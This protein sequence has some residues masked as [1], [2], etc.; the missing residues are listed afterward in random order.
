MPAA[1][2][3]VDALGR[4]CQSRRWAHG[5][6]P[7]A[8][9]GAHRGPPEAPP[10]HRAT[11]AAASDGSAPGPRGAG[12]PA[13]DP[14]APG[15]GK[16]EETPAFPPSLGLPEA[17]TA[18]QPRRAPGLAVSRVSPQPSRGPA[19]GWGGGVVSPG[20]AWG[21]PPGAWQ[22]PPLG[23]WRRLPP[24]LGVPVQTGWFAPG[25]RVCHRGLH[26]LRAPGA[27]RRGEAGEPAS[28]GGVPGPGTGWTGADLR[29]DPHVPRLL[30][31]LPCARGGAAGCGGPHRARAGVRGSSPGARS[32]P[33]PRQPSR[34]GRAA[35]QRRLVPGSALGPAGSRRRAGTGGGGP[36]RRG[37]RVPGVL[38][39]RGGGSS[40]HG[41]S[42]PSPPV[43]PTGSSGHRRAHR[44]SSPSLGAAGG[45]R[46]GLPP[47]L[48]RPWVVNL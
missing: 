17:G 39:K 22:L 14:L 32:R 15:S 25:K 31:P 12:S 40:G 5:P 9:A 42:C 3:P 29:T 34:P 7:R 8:E 10:L 20:G 36:A 6:T 38:Q 47:T 41:P 18:P 1:G 37:P 44:W 45:A 16:R 35:P 28:S 21:R 2:V 11:T 48:A 23:S 46:R 43:I 24:A 27:A 33:G 4:R 30:R 26:L 13:A 19:V